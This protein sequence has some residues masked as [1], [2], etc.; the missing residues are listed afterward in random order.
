MIYKYNKD[1]V[2]T[3]QEL[4]K[5]MTR[6]EKHLWYD[7]LK[8]LPLTVNRQKNIGNYIVDFYISSKNTI[9]EIDGSQHCKEENRTRDE[10]RDSDMQKLG[11]R[12]IRYNNIDINRNFDLVCRDI[13]KRL[14]ID[15]S[16][17]KK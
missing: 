9:I 14:D 15:I 17:L 13:L 2:S 1:L 11:L 8:K 10:L 7:F 3:S 16:E 6:E 12:V 4:R 5:E